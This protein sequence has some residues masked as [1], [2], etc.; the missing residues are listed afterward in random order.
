MEISR[1]Q[2]YD[3]FNVAYTYLEEDVKRIC[4]KNATIRAYH[5]DPSTSPE[6]AWNDIPAKIK[7]IL[8][9][10]RYRGDYTPSVRQFI[11]TP[12]FN[13]DIAEFGRLLS[14]RSVWPNVPPDR[15]NRRIA[16]YAN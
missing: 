12:A 11:Q 7:E 9:D 1:R 5:S 16:Y 15:F 3:L 14:D 10:L 4:Q 2:Q 13:G 8:V 6:Q